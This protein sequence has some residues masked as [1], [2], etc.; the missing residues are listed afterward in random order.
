MSKRASKQLLSSKYGS[1]LSNESLKILDPYW[2][3]HRMKGISVARESLVVVG[4]QQDFA[5]QLLVNR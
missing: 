3:W 4:V 5:L 2:W 1:W